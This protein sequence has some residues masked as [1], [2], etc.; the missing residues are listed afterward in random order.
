MGGSSSRPKLNLDPLKQERDRNENIRYDYASKLS[1]SKIKLVNDIN[2]Y[3]STVTQ[4]HYNVILYQ[5][6]NFINFQ[7]DLNT[8]KN[9]IDDFIS[10]FD[11]KNTNS[12][13]NKSKTN[14]KLI[15]DTYNYIYLYTYCDDNLSAINTVKQNIDLLKSNLPNYSIS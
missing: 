6:P 14:V 9:Q 5:F 10:H 12:L 3:L 11:N 7:I 1:N 4:Y 15:L 8:L 2:L 13:P